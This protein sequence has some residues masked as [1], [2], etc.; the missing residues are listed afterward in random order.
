[1]APDPRSQP[2]PTGS[3][4]GPKR[5][6]P[7][8][9]EQHLGPWRG[10]VRIIPITGVASQWGET[11]FEVRADWTGPPLDGLPPSDRPV[12][13][14]DVYMTA[15]R[16]LAHAIARRVVEQLRNPRVLRPEL[17]GS[18]APS[19]EDRPPDLRLIAQYLGGD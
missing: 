19:G 11:Q 9:D 17:H 5:Q 12:E 15:D 13:A 3:A 16:D 1:M 2:A 10:R 7:I 6:T 18:I 8:F 4:A 14:S